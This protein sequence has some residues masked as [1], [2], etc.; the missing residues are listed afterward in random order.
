MRE[1]KKEGSSSSR[2]EAEEE[3][4]RQ[5]L[6]IAQGFDFDRYLAGLCTNQVVRML[7]YL[8]EQYK[9]NSPTTNRQILHFF[10][11]MRNHDLDST[12]GGK[13]KASASD[14]FIVDEDEEEVGRRPSCHTL[15]HACPALPV[16][17][18]I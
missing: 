13:K 18:S 10:Q 16:W 17:L 7:T 11:R 2:T 14:P 12:R 1:K 5:L 4:G 9:A 3:R 15:L 8:L 6:D